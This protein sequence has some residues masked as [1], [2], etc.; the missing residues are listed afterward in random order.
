MVKLGEL[1]HPDNITAPGAN[2][3]HMNATLN[4]LQRITHDS[5]RDVEQRTGISH[6]TIARA[7]KADQPPAHIVLAV[8]R[9]YGY[10]VLDALRYAGI[11]APEE[12]AGRGAGAA[13]SAYPSEALLYELLKREQAREA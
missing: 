9:A 13:L 4:W 12:T 7:A 6:T 2:M 1:I 5:S 3:K 8:A 11:L 10:N